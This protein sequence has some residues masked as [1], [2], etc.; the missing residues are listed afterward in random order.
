MLLLLPASRMDERNE[1][2]WA[3]VFRDLITQRV[4]FG[5]D[6]RTAMWQ[7]IVEREMTYHNMWYT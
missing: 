6:K 3:G 4:G 2:K 1:A 5:V 7:Y